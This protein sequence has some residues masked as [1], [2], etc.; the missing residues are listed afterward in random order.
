MRATLTILGLYNYDTS[1]FENFVVPTGV[2][3]A[4]AI[5]SICMDNAEL[6]I[7]YPEPDTMKFL[8]GLWSTRM[9]PVWTRVFN[10]I[11]TQYNPLENY[12]RT[13]NWNQ[14]DTGTHNK[15]GNYTDTGTNTTTHGRT[16]TVTHG[17]TDTVTHAKT[18]THEV[19]GYNGTS[20][21]TSNKDTEGGTTTTAESGTT[22]NAQ[23]GT[24]SDSGSLQHYETEN[25]GNT[26]QTYHTST[27]KGNIGVTTSQEM[28]NQELDV[29][30]RTDIY[31]YISESFKQRFCL[32]VY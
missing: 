12:N 28:L 14:T 26:L 19:A 27:I 21:T 9:L 10:A 29:S 18:D 1:I 25:G 16:D 2:D 15:S 17:K 22:T 32:M 23:S 30:E 20:L 5:N 7:M 4:T 3:S 6:E 11:S 24:T 31:K 8:I 13:E